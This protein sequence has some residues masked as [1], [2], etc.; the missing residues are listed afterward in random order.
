MYGVYVPL[1][2]TVCGPSGNMLEYLSAFSSA[3]APLCV[4][5]PPKTAYDPKLVFGPKA[6]DIPLFVLTVGWKQAQVR[7]CNWHTKM[8][9]HCDPSCTF[10]EP[11][12]ITHTR[13]SQKNRAATHWV[14]YVS[15]PV[16]EGLQWLCWVP[17]APVHPQG[18][19]YPWGAT[20]NRVYR[21]D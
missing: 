15:T 14:M 9:H 13:L 21:V 17:E 1:Q 20:H 4:P 8:S 7:H 2:R 16:S 11:H 3:A 18:L 10:P 19:T 6:D 5:H 12:P